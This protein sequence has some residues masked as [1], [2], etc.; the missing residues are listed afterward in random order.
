MNSN[1]Y[2]LFVCLFTEYQTIWKSFE[3]NTLVY[4]SENLCVYC[5]NGTYEYHIDFIVTREKV[6]SILQYADAESNMFTL[7]IFDTLDDISL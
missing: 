7:L 6:K 2:I 3:E 4:I 5:V 1:V